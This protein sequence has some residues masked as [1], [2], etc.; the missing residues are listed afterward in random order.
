MDSEATVLLDSQKEDKL[1]F[2][3]LIRISIKKGR[4]KKHFFFFYR[5]SL[6]RC[7]KE[8]YKSYTFS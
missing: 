1:M 4:R 2:S 8:I 7:E 5:T 3:G 6:V